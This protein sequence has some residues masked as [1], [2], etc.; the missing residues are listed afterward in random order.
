MNKALTLLFSSIATHCV[1][2][3][4]KILEKETCDEWEMVHFFTFEATMMLA[5]RG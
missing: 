3:T 4:S 5:W 1:I 2:W